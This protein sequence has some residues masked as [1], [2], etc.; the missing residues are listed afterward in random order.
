V[1]RLDA[2]IAN[3]DHST[4]DTHEKLKVTVSAAARKGTETPAPATNGQNDRGY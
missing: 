3:A 4:T 1:H 2:V